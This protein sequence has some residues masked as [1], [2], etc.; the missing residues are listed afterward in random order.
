MFGIIDRCEV[1][2]GKKKKLNSSSSCWV[3][4]T[5]GGGSHVG[6]VTKKPKSRSF[7]KLLWV[8][9]RHDIV[10]ELKSKKVDK[11]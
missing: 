9:R 1:V 8:H 4:S 3:S 10:V 5:T 2:L 11:K 6:R 7:T